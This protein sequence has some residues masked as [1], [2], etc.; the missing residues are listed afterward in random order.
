MW[1]EIVQNRWKEFLIENDLTPAEEERNRKRALFPAEEELSRL[2]RG[3]VEEEEGTLEEE[4]PWHDPK[5]GKLSGPQKGSE[6]SLSRPAVD[7]A[8]W[9]KEKA[10]KGTST[11]NKNKKGETKLTYK[12]GKPSKC[13]R[14]KVSDGEENKRDT[15]CS[16]FPTKYH[17]IKEGEARVSREYVRATF[18]E[19]LDDLK[20]EL[21]DAVGGGQSSQGGCSLDTIIAIM[22]KFALAQKGKANQPPK[23]PKL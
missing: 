15:S 19:E 1:M 14:L 10:K 5:T 20:A 4:N 11:G 16:Q 23:K 6:Y 2:A 17:K 21:I 22:D 9:D 3:L 8:G 13:G 18:A 12:F 7:R